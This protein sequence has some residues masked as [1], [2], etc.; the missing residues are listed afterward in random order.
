MYGKSHPQLKFSNLWGSRWWV[1][2]QQ[3]CKIW[4]NIQTSSDEPF[5]INGSL[6][7]KSETSCTPFQNY[8]IF[9]L[10]YIPLWRSVN[11]T[12]YKDIYI[13]KT[14]HLH[15]FHAH[16]KLCKRKSWI[17]QALLTCAW[18]YTLYSLCTPSDF[19]HSTFS[20]EMLSYSYG[21][22]QTLPYFSDYKTHFFSR[23]M[24][25]KIDLRLICRG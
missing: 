18:Q 17:F 21:T 15:L 24:W 12:K 11:T 10:N 16:K 20:L 8:M 22:V 3:W 5:W 6:S 1:G 4:T 23:K 14:L 7:L 13:V 9:K 19:T 2:G 25:P